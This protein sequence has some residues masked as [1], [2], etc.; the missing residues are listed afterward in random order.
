MARKIKLEYDKIGIDETDEEIIRALSI[1]SQI[2]YRKIAV[3]RNVTSQT[4]SDRI[5]TLRGEVRSKGSRGETKK[6]VLKFTIK[7]NPKSLGYPLEFF[8]ELDINASVMQEVLKELTQIPEIHM[9][10]IT[11]GIHD[12]LCMGNAASVENLHEIVE[13]K[14]SIIPGVNK[15]YTT[16]TLKKVKDNQSLNLDEEAI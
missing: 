8:C 5:K 3:K 14:I 7:V 2:T 9:I 12:I 6:I 11:T 4:I 10:R 1:N 15:T 13:K 16:I